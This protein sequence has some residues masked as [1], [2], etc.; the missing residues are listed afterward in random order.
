MNEKNN[1]G[2]ATTVSFIKKKKKEKTK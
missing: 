2:T 1:T